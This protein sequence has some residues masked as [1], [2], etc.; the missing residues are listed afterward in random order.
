[1]ANNASKVAAYAAAHAAAGGGHGAADAG[2]AAADKLN[3]NVGVVHRHLGDVPAA[4]TYRD[5]P[6]A[7]MVQVLRKNKKVGQSP[8]ETECVNLLNSQ[9]HKLYSGRFKHSRDSFLRN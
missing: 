4:G 5:D 7:C 1:M 6:M 9:K 2:A 3:I 8:Y